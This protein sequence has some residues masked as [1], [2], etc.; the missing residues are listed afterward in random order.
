M[1]RVSVLLLAGVVARA[2]HESQSA[3]PE[4]V[5]TAKPAD[6][7][8]VLAE[9]V[10]FPGHP[11]R[12]WMHLYRYEP[13]GATFDDGLPLDH[14]WHAAYRHRLDVHGEVDG[15]VRL[16]QSV[17]LGRRSGFLTHEVR[18]LV[19]SDPN[20]LVLVLRFAI[21]DGAE[22]CLIP[23][24]RGP[25]SPVPCASDFAEDHYVITD[26]SNDGPEGRMQVKCQWLSDPIEARVTD[27]RLYDWNGREFACPEERWLHI[28]ASAKTL[29]EAQAALCRLQAQISALELR[30]SDWYPGLQKG[31][32]V[33]LG[34]RYRNAEEAKEAVAEVG[35]YVKKG[36]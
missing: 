30:P 6:A 33:V 16:L 17:F 26:L 3:V 8:T 14:R 5:T 24:P 27:T 1:W 12:E 29:E 28:L 10:D 35:G 15:Q 21:P 20:K 23:F 11:G 9:E 19:A 18:R 31:Y 7:I 22:I 4:A 34:G 25:D 13:D 2:Q 36:W 32:W